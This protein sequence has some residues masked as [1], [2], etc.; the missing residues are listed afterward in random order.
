MVIVCGLELRYN[1]L[2]KFEGRVDFVHIIVEKVLELA[3]LFEENLA[4][5]LILQTRRQRMIK[6]T[7]VQEGVCRVAYCV[8]NKAFSFLVDRFRQTLRASCFG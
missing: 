5:D 2:D 3:D 7:L 1:S 4:N 8:L 6:V